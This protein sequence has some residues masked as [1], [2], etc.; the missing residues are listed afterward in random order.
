MRVGAA[1]PSCRHVGVLLGV[2]EGEGFRRH[3]VIGVANVRSLADTPVAE[4][5]LAAGAYH[6]IG[7][8]CIAERTKSVVADAA[9]AGIYRTSYAR[10]TV[11]A[12]EVVNVGYLHFG[13]SHSGR[14]AFGRPLRLEVEVTDWP[15]AEIE[16]FRAR[17]PGLY[18]Q[19]RTRLMVV[20]PRGP[21]APGDDECRR[22]SALKADGKIASVP[23]TCPATSTQAAAPGPARGA[24]PP[25]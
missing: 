9:D 22:L 23:A 16:R 14:S 13:A 1:S 25:R 2:A 6:V 11:A 12:G 7:Y 10:F 3:Q 8:S 4:V 19:M 15:L 20:S 5:E 21:G 24:I 17:R 18:A